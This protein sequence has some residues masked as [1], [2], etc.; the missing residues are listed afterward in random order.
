MPTS[1]KISALAA[2]AALTAAL[3]GCSTG[4]GSPSTPAASSSPASA[5]TLVQRAHHEHGL[6]IYGNIPIQYL[7][8]VIAAFNQL[9]PSIKVSET[10][11]DDNAVFTKYE[12]EAAQG[13]RTADLLIASA[14]AAWVQ[15]EQNGVSAGVTHRVD[16]RA[17]PC[18]APVRPRMKHEQRLRRG[19]HQHLA[20]ILELAHQ[21]LACH[22]IVLCN[23]QPRYVDS[24]QPLHESFPFTRSVGTDYY[25]L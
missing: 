16:Q 23:R 25:V 21:P 19:R 2:A 12:A 11:L 24:Q 8:P 13:A 15:A 3:A 18:I 6:L 17:A 10:D 7:Q 5:A 22:W 14:P 9:Y 4:G 1:L 20:D